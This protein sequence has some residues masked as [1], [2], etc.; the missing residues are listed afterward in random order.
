MIGGEQPLNAGQMADV[1][2]LGVRHLAG[3]HSGVF[4]HSIERIRL[5]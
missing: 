4:L 2:N 3:K 1:K 5:I